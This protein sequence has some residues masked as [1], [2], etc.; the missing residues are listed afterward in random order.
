MNVCDLRNFLVS[1][2]KFSQICSKFAKIAKICLAKFSLISCIITSLY[3]EDSEKEKKKHFCEYSL[4]LIESSFT[5]LP[6]SK[7][8]VSGTTTLHFS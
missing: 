6:V 7:I 5:R 1:R 2:D 3:E 8:S 4:P